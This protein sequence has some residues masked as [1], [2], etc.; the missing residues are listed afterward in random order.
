[1]SQSELHASLEFPVK[2]PILQSVEALINTQKRSQNYVLESRGDNQ[3]QKR[4][5]N[6]S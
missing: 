6:D 1:M 4:K 3:L 2:R 5:T